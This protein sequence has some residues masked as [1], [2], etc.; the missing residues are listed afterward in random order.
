MCCANG[1]AIQ[2]KNGWIWT[3]NRP[4][5]CGKINVQVP[6]KQVSKFIVLAVVGGTIACLAC[7]IYYCVAYCAY[8]IYRRMA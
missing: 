5:I 6:A 1:T 4:M 7:H 8:Q 3:E 2:G